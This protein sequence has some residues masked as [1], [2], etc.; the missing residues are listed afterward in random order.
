MRNGG[1]N[2]RQLQAELDNVGFIT[3]INRIGPKWYE[4]HVNYQIAKKYRKRLSCNRFLV[5]LHKK[6]CIVITKSKTI[7]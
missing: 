2:Y 3:S 7:K 5:R 6:H 1:S 4:V